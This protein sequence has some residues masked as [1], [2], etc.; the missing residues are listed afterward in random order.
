MIKFSKRELTILKKSLKQNNY[1]YTTFLYKRKV[2]LTKKMKTLKIGYKK[3]LK[4][5]PNG[6]LMIIKYD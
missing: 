6:I 2:K 3:Y 1:F 5:F 4:S